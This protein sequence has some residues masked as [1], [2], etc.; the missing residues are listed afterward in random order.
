MWSLGEAFQPT[1]RLGAYLLLICPEAICGC[2]STVFSFSFC[3]TIFSLF[4]LSTHRFIS[5]GV[6]AV[7]MAFSPTYF[8]LDPVP[9]VPPDFS[10]YFFKL[11]QKC[12]LFNHCHHLTVSWS[13]VTLLIYRSSDTSEIIILSR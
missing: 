9:S 4:L 5:P 1:G 10:I 8:F 3:H 7:L 12:T 6:T 13:E 11:S 2:Y